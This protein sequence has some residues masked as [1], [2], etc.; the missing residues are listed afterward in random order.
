MKTGFSCRR[1]VGYRADIRRSRACRGEWTQ[2]GDHRAVSCELDEPLPERGSRRRIPFSSSRLD[3][4][5][6][7]AMSFAYSIG[8]VVLRQVARHRAA[9]ESCHG[10]LDEGS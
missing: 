5:G 6:K 2:A 3:A 7:D 10:G 1:A 9:P 4:E 8:T